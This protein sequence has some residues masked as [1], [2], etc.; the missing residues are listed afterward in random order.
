MLSK[1]L[2]HATILILNELFCRQTPRATCLGGSS[3]A[4]FIFHIL[5]IPMR[6][7]L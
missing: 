6:F 3:S 4:W 2:Q 1:F 7:S 5:I